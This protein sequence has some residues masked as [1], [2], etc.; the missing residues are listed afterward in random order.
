[1]HK[2][3]INFRSGVTPWR[4]SPGV[5]RPLPPPR[6]ATARSIPSDH[7]TGLKGSYFVARRDRYEREGGMAMNEEWGEEGYVET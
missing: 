5:V 1:M 4:V 2:K 7:L 3:K 6:D